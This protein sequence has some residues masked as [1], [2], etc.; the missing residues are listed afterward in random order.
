MAAPASPAAAPAPAP[1]RPWYRQLY[2]WVLTAIVT[3]VLTGWLW[4]SAGTALEPVGTTFVAAIKMLIAPIVFLTVVAGIG[5]VDSLGR[6]G[7]V[8]L[9]SLL[10][11]QAGTL[12]ALLVGLVAVN[13]FQPGAGVH[14]DPGELRLEGD[15]RQYVKDGQDQD[16][17]HFL[18]D[19]VPHSAVGAFAEGNVLQVIFLSVLF[20]V[21]LKAVGPVGEPIVEGVHRLSA[22]AFKILHY[23]MLA[24]PVGAFGAMAYTIGAYG[25]STL[26]SLGQLIGLFYGT[27]AFF[28]VVVLGAVTAALRIN[29]FRLLRYLREEFVLVLGTSSS[30]SALPRLMQKLEGLG[31]RRDIV[32]LTVP[33][34]Y[35]FNLDGS[36]LYLSLA[37]VYIAQATDTPLSIGQQLG[38]LAVMILTSKG[39]GGITGAGFIALAATLSTVG[40]VPAAGIMLIFGIDKFMSECRALTNLAGNSVATLVVARWEN[41][42]DAEHVNKVLKARAPDPAPA[43]EADGRAEAPV[44]LPTK[45]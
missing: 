31:V 11:F 29:I 32:G 35:S 13:V 43:E 25:I 37:A 38:L 40:T 33:T 45:A 36:S 7:R 28:V 23:V 12:A 39:S 20:G 16:W 8:G 42:L 14:A 21:A 4:P 26:T 2:F 9:K 30:E 19:I 44:E 3:G 17:W 18:T 27:S 6:V 10:Y 5:G 24:A 15:A 1:K 22:V 41:D 34:G